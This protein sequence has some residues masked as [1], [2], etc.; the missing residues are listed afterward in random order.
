M[1]EYGTFAQ[2]MN[3]SISAGFQGN[4]FYNISNA[5]GR[6]IPD[7]RS[8]KKLAK[9]IQRTEPFYDFDFRGAY[10]RIFSSFLV[11][12]DFKEL[13]RNLYSSEGQLLKVD[14]LLQFPD[15]ERRIL[16]VDMQV[17]DDVTIKKQQ[18]AEQFYR[19]I[20]ALRKQYNKKEQIVAVQY[21]IDPSAR[22]NYQFFVD[23]QAKITILGVEARVFYGQELFNY[24]QIPEVYK[25]LSEYFKR[26]KTEVLDAPSLNFDL[27]AQNS[28]IE[29]EKR[30]SAEKDALKVDKFIALLDNDFATDEILPVLFPTGET[31]RILIDFPVFNSLKNSDVLKEKIEDFLNNRLIAPAK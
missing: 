4:L 31:L 29:I 3:Q 23:Q 16:L 2:I 21:F 20:E 26:W 19:Q 1:I 25:Q 14:Q 10:N 9:L 30:M 11:S 28:A 6:Y 22:E 5:P 8:A 17:R 18:L 15:D 27:I 12:E 24:I 13:N 7:F